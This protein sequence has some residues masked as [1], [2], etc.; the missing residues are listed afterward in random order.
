MRNNLLDDL[1][2]NNLALSKDLQTFVSLLTSLPSDKYVS[3][4]V[5]KDIPNTY[6][7]FSDVHAR[8]L[9]VIDLLD[10][11][12]KLD[13]SPI[14]PNVLIKKITANLNIFKSVLDETYGTLTSIINNFGHWTEINYT[15]FILK[16]EKGIESS[17]SDQFFQLSV[18]SDELLAS[19]C[20]ILPF[21]KPKS[22]YRFPIAARELARINEENNHNLNR[23]LELLHKAQGRIERLQQLEANLI[24]EHDNISRIRKDSDADRKAIAEQLA[25]TTEQAASIDQTRLKASELEV[26]IEAS[27]DALSLFERQMQ[28]REARFATGEK[29]LNEVTAALTAKNHTIDEL[30]LKA[31]Q[32][33]SLATV[34]GLASNFGDMKNTLTQELKWAGYAFYG[35]ITFLFISAIPLFALI[36]LPLAKPLLEYNFPGII[37][38]EQTHPEGHWQYLGQVIGR[39]LILFP[40]IWLVRFTSI[41]YSSLFRLREHYAYKYSMAVAVEGFKKQAPEYG[42]EITAM[43]LEQ[44]AF[45]PVDKLTHSSQ[46]KEGKPP[47][48]LPLLLQKFRKHLE[49]IDEDRK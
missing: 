43:V 10:D 22:G 46:V 14:I 25:K 30:N 7:N 49:I 29:A 28:D 33:L 1:R 44:L 9:I 19:I 12:S 21:L 36:M 15:D 37:I 41:R 45:N 31:D 13:P 2:E 3:F 38:V 20:H 11:F 18:K 26:N 4:D 23:T 34:A 39:I 5:T 32:M 17:V 6:D 16:T 48:F 40:A 27:H 24:S 35:A 47:F 8:L 42:Q